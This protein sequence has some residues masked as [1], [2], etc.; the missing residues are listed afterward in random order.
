MTTSTIAHPEAY[1]LWTRLES[2]FERYHT[3]ISYI[4]TNQTRLQD[5]LRRYLCLRCAGFLEKL[6]QV[7]INL[8]LDATS[9]GPALEF[10]KS[11]FSHTPNLNAESFTRLLGRFGD[12]HAARFDAFLTKPLRDSLNDLSS[13]RNP[14]AHGDV[15]GGQKLDPERYRRLCKEVY[16]W[17]TSDLLTP[18]AVIVHFTDPPNESTA[19]V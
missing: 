11:F 12:D 16:Q 2:E 19:H 3:A 6:V 5:D 17:L 13:V 18:V 8:Y 1:A 14:I 15:T 7:C 10:A 4:P 9:G